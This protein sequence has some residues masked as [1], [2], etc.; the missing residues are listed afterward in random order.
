MAEKYRRSLREFTKAAWPTIEPGVDFQN[1][2]HID[3][4]SDHLEA[5]VNGD[6]KRLIIN[7][8]PRHMK[9]IS[10]AVAMPAWTW[11]SQPHKKFL[12]ASYA[13]SLSIRD[14]TKCRRLIDSPW[15][16]GALR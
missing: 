15:Y 13:S 14:S 9:S 5:V 11:V 12:Y 1:N 7:V 3:A 2:W 6:I 8:P 4:I 16:R 10:V